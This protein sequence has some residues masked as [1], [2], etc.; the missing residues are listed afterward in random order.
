M[1]FKSAVNVKQQKKQINISKWD[2]ILKDNGLKWV[3][4]EFKDGKIKCLNDKKELTKEEQ[5]QEIIDILDQISYAIELNRYKYM[6]KYDELHGEGAY[7]RL[8]Y[9]EPIYNNLELELSL[10]SEEEV[11]SDYEQN[12][13]CD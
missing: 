9:M 7:E 3:Q 13:Y 4:Y 12:I 2:D 1:D 6:I 8:Y 11:N 5:Q 10:D